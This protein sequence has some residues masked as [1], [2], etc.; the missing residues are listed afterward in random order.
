MDAIL[1]TY[2]LVDSTGL[3]GFSACHREEFCDWLLST[4]CC[5]HLWGEL[6]GICPGHTAIL[7]AMLSIQPKAG[8]H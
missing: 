7:T 3:F 1:Y 2:Q 4:K 5:Q 6:Q 8:S